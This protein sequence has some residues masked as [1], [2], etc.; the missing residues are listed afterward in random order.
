MDRMSTFNEGEFVDRGGWTDPDVEANWREAE[1]GVEAPG[2]LHDRVFDQD[3]DE[4][5]RVMDTPRNGFEIEIVKGQPTINI[6]PEQLK[7]VYIDEVKAPAFC[8]DCGTKLV[9]G[10][11]PSC[12]P[13]EFWTEPEY[14]GNEPGD[15][16]YAFKP[17]DETPGRIRPEQP[18]WWIPE[19][20]PLPA[21]D[22]KPFLAAIQAEINKS[23]GADPTVQPPE[24][25]QFLTSSPEVV[26]ELPYMNPKDA[27]AKRE[28]KTRLDLLE[29]AGNKAIADALEFGAVTKDYGV[30]NYLTVPISARIYLAAMQRHIDALKLMEDLAPDSL[31]HHLGHIGAN[32]HIW[33]A[34]VEAGTFV[35]DRGPAELGDNPLNQTGVK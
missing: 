27:Q 23:Q 2:T 32:V 10:T 8:Q 31:V 35:D 21:P 28:R 4:R 7:T 30:Q 6:G 25:K 15:E 12:K 13:R 20:G 11:C 33:L 34:A 19:G 14:Q 24:D 26:G 16:G 5:N 29:P 22:I 3:L 1:A 18:K 9:A 17:F